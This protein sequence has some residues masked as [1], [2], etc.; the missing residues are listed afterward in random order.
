[1]TQKSMTA[2]ECCES[3]LQTKYLLGKPM[4]MDGSHEDVNERLRVVMQ[5]PNGISCD[6]R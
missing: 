3:Y 4:D 5:L 1:M 2:S 6:S